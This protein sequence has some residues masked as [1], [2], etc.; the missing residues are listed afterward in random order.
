MASLYI[1]HTDDGPLKDDGKIE[2]DELGVVFSIGQGVTSGG[3]QDFVDPEGGRLD[4]LEKTHK[5][6]F[7][8]KRDLVTRPPRTRWFGPGLR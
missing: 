3:A 1:N 6:E 2:K 4:E 5:G 7:G 8:T